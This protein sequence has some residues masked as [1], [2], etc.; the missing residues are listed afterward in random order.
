[1]PFDVGTLETTQIISV[2]V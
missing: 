2:Y 1:M